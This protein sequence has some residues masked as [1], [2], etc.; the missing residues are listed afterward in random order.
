MAGFALR[1]A[2]SI[3]PTPGIRRYLDVGCGNGFITELVG[4]KFDEVF[5][6]DVEEDRLED[7]RAH[8]DYNGR[9]HIDLMSAAEIGFSDDYFSLLTC[10]EVLEHVPDPDA[11]A[12]EIV[13]TCK[14][15]GV[16]VISA[17]RC[18]FRSKITGS[19]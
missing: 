1:W 3:E 14:R 9:F 13:R 19:A 12:S 18:G 8:A 17:L 11:S 16:V 10:F 15:G 4:A 7:F 2:D 5:G 6:I